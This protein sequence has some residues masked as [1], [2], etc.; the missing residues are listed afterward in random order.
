[1][2]FKVGEVELEFAVELRKDV[3]AKA[4]FKAWVVTAGTE[5]GAAKGDTHRVKISLTPQKSDG[6]D[7]YVHGSADREEGPGD[8]S[9]YIPDWATAPGGIR[10][11]SS[12]GSSE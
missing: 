8:L 5:L 2:Q 9:G 1:M 6:G 12:R 11:W 7:L 4:G 10:G 3:K